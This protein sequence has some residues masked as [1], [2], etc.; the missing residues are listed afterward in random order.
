MSAIRRV[1]GGALFHVPHP[2]PAPAPLR[3][4]GP[5]GRGRAA[6]PAAPRA[7][8]AAVTAVSC[9]ALF[10]LGVNTT[11]INTA[12]RAMAADLGVGTAS[13]GWAV[14][15]YMLAVAAV[16]VPGGRLGDM[17]GQRVTVVTGSLVFAAG[18]AVVAASGSE[19]VLLAGRVLQGVGAAALMPSTMAV[20]RL[21]WPRER[22]GAALGLWGAVAG[23]AFAV[24]PLIGGVFTDGPS[25]RWLWWSSTG[26]ALLVA[27]AAVFALRSL[28]RGTGERGLDV[29]GVLL[30]S[31]GLTGLLVALQQI[32][33][34][35]AASPATVSCFV[36]AALGLGALARVESRR[37][38]PLLHL[39]LL[40][41]PPL[42]AACI[43]TAVNTLFLIGFLYFFNLYALSPD[44]LGYSA[45]MA[46]L[47][48]LPYGACV[49]AVSMGVGPLCD[50]VGY[51][52]PVA[53]GIALSGAG[54]LWLSGVSGDS[55]YGAV[56]P[57]SLVLG[58]GVGITLSAP[59]AA[60]LRALD[61]GRAGEA[62]GIIN[63][64][65]YVTA[66]LA[67]SAG[68]LVFLTRGTARLTGVLRD[69]G[70]PGPGAA[71]AD[72]LLSGAALPSGQPVGPAVREVFHR[73]TAAGL[74]EGF[75]SV[76]F[77][78]GLLALAAIPLWLLLM[79][80]SRPAGTTAP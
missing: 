3:D 47:A 12:L 35:G 64:V 23:L 66:A 56:L 63:V 80:T 10:L 24:G 67:V 17:V 20:L 59:S 74:A 28:P 65:R 60:G 55:G 79:P 45:V 75:A 22:Q 52:W 4:V 37:A 21:A 53:A 8:P 46:S 26:W 6:A 51:R 73:A 62:A 11:G 39:G 69:A 25:W 41:E 19:G 50:R 29:P 70:V 44:T 57:G 33:S 1:L 48:L 61:G 13:L 38:A 30:L 27:L 76:M 9:A 68:T 42:V 34:W 18:S 36:V 54:A 58:A 15:A 7:R 2:Y 43:G 14:G 78:L 31:V 40:R 16:V 49:F 77:W 32:P 5:D 72:R 71:G